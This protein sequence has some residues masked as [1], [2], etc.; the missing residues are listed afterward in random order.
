ME[1][2]TF[3]K[4]QYD[5][6]LDRKNEINNSLS[7]P[8]GILTALIAGLFYATTNFNFDDNRILSVV[9]A[10]IGLVSIYFL[11]KSIYHLIKA[12]SDLHD[13]YD[14]AYLNDTDV[15]DGYFKDL[16]AY[17]DVINHVVPSA[18]DSYQYAKKDFE[19]YLLKEYIKSTGINQKNNKAKVFERFQCNQYMI[20]ALISLSLLI[21]PFA[22]D[23]GISKGKDKVQKVKIES[24]YRLT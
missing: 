3:Y 8:I 6:A 15:L 2:E 20:Y 11:S 14:Y 19:E 13:G 7:T 9:F 16:V 21:I 1:Q 18:T 23:F 24:V 12:F 5:R 4:D 17:Y 10:F 22:I